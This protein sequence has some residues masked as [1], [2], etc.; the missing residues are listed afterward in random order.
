MNPYTHTEAEAMAVLRA[1]QTALKPTGIGLL[2]DIKPTEYMHPAHLW[3]ILEWLRA[4]GSVRLFDPGVDYYTITE[5][6]LAV[7]QESTWSVSPPST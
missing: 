7:L 2:L 6:G 3:R 5:H 4:E 1:C